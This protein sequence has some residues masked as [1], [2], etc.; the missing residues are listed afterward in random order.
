MKFLTP[1]QMEKPRKRRLRKKLRLAEFQ[2]FGF[3][4]ELTYDS[5]AIDL[6]DALDKLIDFVEAQ[7]WAF[8]GGG[9]PD[10]TEVT[11]YLCQ[12]GV[13]TLTEEDREKTREWMEAQPWC[14]GFEIGPLSDCWHNFF[15]WE[16]ADE[17]VA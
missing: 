1:E 13:G 3:S 15:D 17:V 8:G 16:E 10:E 11:G 12:A 2:E 9:N 6:D 5:A 14:K 7:G 4:F